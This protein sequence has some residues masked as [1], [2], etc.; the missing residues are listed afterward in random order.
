MKIQGFKHP[1][2]FSSDFQI[3]MPCKNSDNFPVQTS[4]SS[5]PILYVKVVPNFWQNTTYIQDQLW[6]KPNCH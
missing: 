1:N 2:Q 4:T 6:A 3:S 5:V